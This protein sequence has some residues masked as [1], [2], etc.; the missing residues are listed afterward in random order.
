MIQWSRSAAPTSTQ[1]SSATHKSPRRIPVRRSSSV[2]GHHIHMHFRPGSVHCG[3][4]VLSS[5]HK[6]SPLRI[7]FTKLLKFLSKQ[8]CLIG[9]LLSRL[10]REG[11]F[12]HTS[13]DEVILFR[14][15]DIF[16]STRY[17]SFTITTSI[18]LSRSGSCSQTRSSTPG[19]ILFMI[20]LC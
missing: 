17:T 18:I 12:F 4:R 15:L 5:T 10:I 9:P 2:R 20:F 1:T 6:R 7:L 16:I 13:R 19:Y 14:I 11:V 8:C 3:N